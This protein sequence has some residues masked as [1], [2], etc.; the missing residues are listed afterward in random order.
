MQKPRRVSG[1]CPHYDEPSGLCYLS[2]SMP[3]SSHRDHNCKSDR[4]CKTCGNYE[5]WASGRNYTTK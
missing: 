1:W 2:E 5:A 4:N 3:S